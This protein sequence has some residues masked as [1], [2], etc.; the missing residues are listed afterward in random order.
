VLTLLMTG[1]QPVL[2]RIDV[3]RMGHAIHA[4]GLI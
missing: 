3:P 1:G 4:A 2:E